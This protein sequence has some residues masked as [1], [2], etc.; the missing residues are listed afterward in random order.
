VDTITEINIQSSIDKLI[1]RRSSFVVAHRLSTVRN[2]D[3]IVVLMHG[4][5]IEGGDHATLFKQKGRYFE[6][7]TS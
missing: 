7:Y 1:E 4:K 2:A 5:I 6:L 3:E